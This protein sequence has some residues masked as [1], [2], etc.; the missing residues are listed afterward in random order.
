MRRAKIPC[1][2][3]I[4]HLFGN[5][6]NRRYLLKKL[7]P[8]LPINLTTCVN[9]TSFSIKGDQALKTGV[10]IQKQSS[11]GVVKKRFSENM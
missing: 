11:I 3:G 2:H 10:I 4:N 7:Q 5:D 1:R 9:L 6:A 8:I